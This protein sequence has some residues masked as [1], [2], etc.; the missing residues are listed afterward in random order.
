MALDLDKALLKLQKSENDL[1]A[2]EVRA[3]LNPYGYIQGLE[4]ILEKSQTCDPEDLG[5]LKFQSDIYLAMLRKSLPDLKAVE[6]S[7]KTLMDI[8]NSDGSL[9]SPTVIELVC[10]EVE[11][12]ECVNQENSAPA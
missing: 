6:V 4:D 3:L 5:R 10:P 8:T 11:E 12:V 9:R 7:G 1:R 2:E